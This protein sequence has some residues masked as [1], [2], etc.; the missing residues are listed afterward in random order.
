MDDVLSLLPRKDETVAEAQTAQPAPDKKPFWTGH[1][2]SLDLTIGTAKAYGIRA[3]KVIVRADAQ[4]AGLRLTQLTGGLA[5]G[6]LS[7]RGQLA[8]KPGISNG[9]Y[10]LAAT[11]SLTQFN[12][13]EVAQ[14]VPAAKDF[15]QGKG[16]AT[17][18][19]TS[20][21]GT[22]GEL[23]GRLQADVQLTSRGGV[24]RA[25]GDKNSSMAL[26]ANKAGDVTEV[27]GGIALIAGALTRNQEQGEKI[28]KVGAAM[29]AAAKLQKAV[30]E[31]AYTSA[32]IKASRLASGTIKLDLAD[33]RSPTLQL[34]AKGGINIDPKAAFADWP[35]AF[36]TQ[37]R[38]SGEFAEYFQVLGFGAGPS[39]ADGFTDG[40]GVNV[41]GSLNQIRTDLSEKLQAA[42]DR[43]RNAPSATPAGQAPQAA[44]GGQAAPTPA[45]RKRN[46]LGDLLNELGR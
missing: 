10:A 28:A 7:G 17:A 12:F 18:S 6:T 36:T 29:T 37:L 23:A 39:P 9:P 13:G 1:T 32:T 43:T 22:P 3:E 40:P 26:S 16:D 46:P 30:A 5:E 44:P 2:G 24:I 11:V 38:G 34:S 41:T 35:M 25:F 4:D 15:L 42:I 21:S 45:P 8:F 20:V 27:L 33:I 31:F 19:V 14:A